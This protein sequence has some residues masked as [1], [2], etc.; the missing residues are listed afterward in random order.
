M[1]RGRGNSLRRFILDRNVQDLAVLLY[2]PTPGVRT[3]SQTQSQT[4]TQT[5]KRTPISNLIPP[6]PAAWILTMTM[7]ALLALGPPRRDE[8]SKTSPVAEANEAV[9]SATTNEY[10]EHRAHQRTNKHRSTHQHPILSQITHPRWFQTHRKRPPPPPYPP[11]PPK[12]FSKPSSR[13]YRSRSTRKSFGRPWCGIPIDGRGIPG[14]AAGRRG[15][16]GCGISE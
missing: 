14:L 15:R 9:S 1:G 3:Q 5:K 12:P 10:A 13:K 8:A 11:C 6:N 16:P 2:P 7:A 4:Q